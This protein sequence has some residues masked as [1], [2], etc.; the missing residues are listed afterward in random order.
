MDLKSTRG[1][2]IELIHFFTEAL[3][4]NSIYRP[5]FSRRVGPLHWDWFFPREID[6]LIEEDL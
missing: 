6:F 4:S 1:K 2:V 5:V 3:S